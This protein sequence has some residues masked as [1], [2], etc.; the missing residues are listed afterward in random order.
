MWS[1][2]RGKDPP[3]GLEH[4]Q[5]SPVN[6]PLSAPY[7][8]L[9]EWLIREAPWKEWYSFIVS[10]VARGQIAARVSPEGTAYPFSLGGFRRERLTRSL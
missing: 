8:Q 7:A 6:I 2:V 10:D 1:H 5:V 3:W 4:P 9:Y